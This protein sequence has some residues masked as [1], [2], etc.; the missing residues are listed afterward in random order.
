MPV[1]TEEMFD[2]ESVRDGFTEVPE[3]ISRTR[4]RTLLRQISIEMGIHPITRLPLHPDVPTDASSKDRFPRPMTCGT[5]VHRIVQNLGTE[6]NYPKCDRLT[7]ER[8]AAR[9]S[10]TDTPRWMPACVGYN[11]T[12][13]FTWTRPG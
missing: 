13:G 2:R 5:C 9:T 12:E 10:S 7:K 6:R 8:L 1:V 3:G 4:R 11:P